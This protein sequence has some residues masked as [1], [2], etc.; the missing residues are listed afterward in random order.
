MSYCAQCGPGSEVRGELLS[1]D[2]FLD[3]VTNLQSVSA[4][5]SFGYLCE[6]HLKEHKELQER[7]GRETKIEPL[8]TG[9]EIIK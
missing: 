3:T 7:T 9:I 8:S 4:W 2:N 1:R 6:R 5:E